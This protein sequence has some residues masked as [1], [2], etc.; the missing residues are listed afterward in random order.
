MG[1][2]SKK[3]YKSYKFFSLGRIKPFSPWGQGQYSIVQDIVYP[4]NICKEIATILQK[5]YHCIDLAIYRNNGT[6]RLPLC[7]KMGDNG[8]IEKRKLT[9]NVNNSRL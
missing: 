3:K 5:K 1:K 4:L 6:L 9:F 8:I 2:N 7:Y